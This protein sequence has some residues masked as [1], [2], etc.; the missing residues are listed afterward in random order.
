MKLRSIILLSLLSIGA[1]ECQDVNDGWQFTESFPETTVT[2]QGIHSPGAPSGTTSTSSEARAL[3]AS[4]VQSLTRR[5]A[6]VCHC[7][8]ISPPARV[9][10]PAATITTATEGRFISMDFVYVVRTQR[11]MPSRPSPNI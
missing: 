3:N 2:A 1:C 7:L 4:Q 11:T 5:P 8:A 6:S 10:R 9:P